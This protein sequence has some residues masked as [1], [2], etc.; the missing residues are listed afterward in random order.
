MSIRPM[1]SMTLSRTQ[2]QVTI[3]DVPVGSGIILVQLAACVVWMGRLIG[4][5]P[6]WPMIALVIVAM[7][8]ECIPI[9]NIIVPLGI[10]GVVIWALLNKK[11]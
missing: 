1:P 4:D 11:G 5:D 2:S 8:I 3:M 6:H 7:V 9:V 10:L